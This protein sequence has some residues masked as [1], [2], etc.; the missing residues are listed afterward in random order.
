MSGPSP[1]LILGGF[2]ITPEAYAPMAAAIA[3]HSHQPVQVV[4]A[5]RGDWLLT[6]WSLGWR[7][8]LDRSQALLEG[9]A[10]G[11][12]SGKVNLVGHSSGGVMLR[13]LLGDEPFAGRVYG[14]RHRVDTLLSLGSPHSAIR[15]TAL[16]RLV[17]QRYP[18][19]FFAGSVRYLSVAGAI[20]PEQLRPRARRLMARSF[21]AIN[22][23]PGSRGD[24]LVPISSALL[25]GSEQRLL[26]GVGHGGWFAERWYGSA[27][28][29]PQ[30]VP[31]LAA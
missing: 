20:A 19:A 16:R 11:S 25:A 10:A 29:L 28:V 31:W 24:G 26:E 4:P 30:W 12:P 13:L 18:G 17:D 14:L 8:L 6:S 5:S 15:G 21:G 22:N 3:A 27:T 23:D 7:R 1:T 2:L 9:L